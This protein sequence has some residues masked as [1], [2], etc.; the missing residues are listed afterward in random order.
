VANAIMDA[1]GA[2]LSTA[3]ATPERVWRALGAEAE[4]S[5]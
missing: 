4:E 1:I 5:R 2:D 3:P